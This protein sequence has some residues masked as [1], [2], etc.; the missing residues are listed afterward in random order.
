MILKKQ[1]ALGYARIS[2]ESENIENQ[3][4]ELEKFAELN[5]F[6]L[7]EV[8]KDIGVSG[9]KSA[10]EREGFKKT[11]ETSNLL[12]IK[13]IIV[14]DLTRLG[15]DLFDLV[16]TYKFLLE[17]GFNVL[18]VKHPELNAKPNSPVS[19]AL[20]RALL[21]MLGIVSELERAFIIERTK[22]GLERAKREGK[23]LGRKLVNIPIDKVQEYL[24]K[25]LSKKDIYR[26]L[27]DMGFLRY[28]E[29]GIEKVLSY[30]RF[31]KRLKHIK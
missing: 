3:I 27:I 4:L 31:L 15:R 18:F 30:D 1:K 24:R 22:A 5:N 21:T 7:V 8:F 19:E 2:L 14:Y 20:R 10:L 16:N 28:K 29:K 6:D 12:N 25:G 11:L 26:L 9:G 13:T 23:K 17:Q